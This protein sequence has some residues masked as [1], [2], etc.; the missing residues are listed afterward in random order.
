MI[1]AEQAITLTS[2]VAGA[3]RLYLVGESD[4]GALSQVLTVT[5]PAYVS[6]DSGGA[7]NPSGPSGPAVAPPGGDGLGQK[8]PDAAEISDWARPYIKELADAGILAGR[9]NGTLDPKGIITRAEFTK[10]A[11]LG[12]KLTAGEAPKTFTDVSDGD[13]FKEFVDIASSTGIVQ[14]VSETA[15]APNRRITRQ[16]LC[17]IVYRALQT[18]EIATPTPA[19][20]PFTDEAQIAAYALDAVK[21]LK[22]IGVISGRAHGQFDPRAYATREETAKI[23]SGVMAYVKT[24]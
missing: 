13:W 22:E 9:A 14:G 17:T 18:L 1:A 16:D 6:S 2:L 5:I 15:F 24:A 10:M 3:K 8:F 21:A 20:T 23:L 12:L 11:V 4:A 7:K 19:G